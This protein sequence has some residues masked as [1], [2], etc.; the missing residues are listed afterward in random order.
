MSDVLNTALS[1]ALSEISW[2][3]RF[4]IPELNAENK[5]LLDEVSGKVIASL[6]FIY[7]NTTE[8]LALCKA[9][10]RE[11]EMERH[12]TAL[13]E[14]ES[15]RLAQ[16]TAKMENEQRSLAERATV[17]ENQIFKAKQK[18]EEF[19]SQMNWDQQ[20]MDAFL[21]ESAR[22]DE[23]AMA[24]IKYAQQDEQRIKSLTLGIEK[25]TLDANE[26]RKVLD[27]EKAETTSAQIALDKTTE[28]L[29][30]AHLETQQLI[31]QWENTIKQMKQRDSEM[32]QCAL[33]KT[34]TLNA[35]I[36][37]MKHL[38]DTQRNNNQEIERKTTIANRQALKLRQDLKE[39]ENNCR[40]LQDELDT[41]KG[42]LDK[43][44]SDVASATSNISRMK[45]DIQDSNRKS[46][47]SYNVSLSKN[48][49]STTCVEAERVTQLDQYL[50][51]EEQAIKELD[52]QLRDCREELFRSKEHL[53]GLKTKEKDAVAQISRSKSTITNLE[54]QLR[55]LDNDLMKQQMTI[56]EQ[57]SIPI[58]Y[59]YEKQ[60][61]DM[62]ITDLTKAVE[63]K[64]KTANMLTSTLKESEDDIYILRK[65]MDK[66]EAQK[67]DL[68]TK[69]EELI[70]DCNASENELK[71][72]QLRKQGNMVE[73]N[74]MKMEV[75]RI[76]DLLY[77]KAD[78][79]LSLE[80]RKLMLQKIIKDR[81]EEIKAAREVL[82]KQLK[83]SDKES[84][85]LNEKLSKIN[86]LKKRFEILTF[87]MAAPEGE[88]EKA[89]AYYITKVRGVQTHSLYRT[90]AA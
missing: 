1:A 27:R 5:A 70:L 80:K 26:K 6:L 9:K 32:Q 16:E 19:R 52:V 38:L 90:K 61:L 56:T 89:L 48:G 2:D 51:D 82:S 21:E 69:T 85:E 84:I 83:I 15:G 74:I 58:L 4:A 63:E 35:T 68:T 62:K 8:I 50:K 11:I 25:K 81:E 47:K 31:H 14:R 13:A 37:Q 86:M 18:L 57:E 23:D 36:T 3:K 73:Y 33:V 72:L 41:C 17:L 7:D 53:Q 34:V 65:K 44:T 43:T 24:I 64:K 39:Q 71:R 46:V 29:Q 66:S 78:T 42:T 49:S 10:E 20:T 76:R 79:V 12:L 67:R 30:Q 28:N 45:K 59:I 77:N 88:E 54:S 22:R 40:R 60:M 75:K 55:K 87:S